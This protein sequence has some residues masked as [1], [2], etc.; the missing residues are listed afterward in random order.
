M[1]ETIDI[2]LS[3]N[4]LLLAIVI[5]AVFVLAGIWLFLYADSFQDNPVRLFRNPL[6]VKGVG[7]IG[8]LFFG[9]LGIIG[10]KK[11]SDKKVGL[12]IDDKGITDNSNAAS[13]GLIEWDDITEIFTK[14]VMTTKFLMIK[15]K[16]PEKYIARAQ[17][18]MKAKLMQSNMKM[19]GTPL[20]VTSNTLKY[21]F[22]VLEQL[23]QTAYRQHKNPA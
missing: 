12:R 22:G 7:V 14:Q 4:K 20:A 1:N 21:D 18:G 2:P 16:D 23:I 9:A 8:V 6:V 19:Y 11:V 10:L 15:V 17:G 3:K 5:S 13:A